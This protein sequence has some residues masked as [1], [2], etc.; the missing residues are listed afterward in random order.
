[1]EWTGDLDAFDQA[2][3]ETQDLAAF[4]QALQKVP[5]GMWD[6][7]ELRLQVKLGAVRLIPDADEVEGHGITRG[8][9]TPE[10]LIRRAEVLDAKKRALREEA[11]AR[12]AGA[13]RPV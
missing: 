7:V 6:V 1:M 4:T 3:V 9:V 10:D 8:T 12:R 13:A 11:A 2:G 5:P